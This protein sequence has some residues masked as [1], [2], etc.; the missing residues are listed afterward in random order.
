MPRPVGKWAV[1]R[2][3]LTELDEFYKGNL[4]C[5]GY[6]EWLSRMFWAQMKAA[7]TTLVLYF[8]IMYPLV[9]VLDRLFGEPFDLTIYFIRAT[10]WLLVVFGIYHARLLVARSR[11]ESADAFPALFERGIQVANVEDWRARSYFLP[12]AEVGRVE[13]VR[14]WLGNRLVLHMAQ[15]DQWFRLDY[16]DALL[17]GKGLAELSSQLHR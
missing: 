12:Y 3:E 17:G 1:V 11:L 2:G 14:R 16:Y 4:L 13:T 5:Y 9:F 8:L 15:S 7:L 10:F 6:R